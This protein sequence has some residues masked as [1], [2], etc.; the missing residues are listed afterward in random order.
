VRQFKPT[1]LIGASGQPGAFTEEIIKVIHGGCE[2]PIIFALSN[3]TAKIEA[4]PEHVLGWTGGAA[5]VATG[6][7]FGPVRL[8]GVT[9]HIGQC[10]NVFVFPGIGLGATVVR[11]QWLPETAF[12]A[13]ARAVYESTGRPGTPGATIFPPLSRLRDVSYCVAVAVGRALIDAGA[14]PQL[15]QPALEQRVAAAMWEPAYLR[16][17]AG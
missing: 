2:R 16:Y 5:I 1:I 11:A 13:A 7:P 8:G 6:S 15:A 17:R 14:A 3:P 4:L 9:H 12:A 10:N